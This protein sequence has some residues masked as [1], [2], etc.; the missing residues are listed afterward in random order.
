MTALRFDE[1]VFR[2]L[3]SLAQSGDVRRL[4]GLPPGVDPIMFLG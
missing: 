4:L 3:L 2:R 1:D